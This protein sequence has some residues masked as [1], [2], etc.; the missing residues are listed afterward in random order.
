MMKYFYHEIGHAHL[1]GHTSWTGMMSSGNWY[2]FGL[3]EGEANHWYDIYSTPQGDC[4]SWNYD[5]GSSD[6]E[7]VCEPDDDEPD[8]S[9]PDDPGTSNN[10]EPATPADIEVVQSK[11]SRAR[12]PDSLKI[13]RENSPESLPNE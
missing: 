6:T 1:L 13:L 2:S 3:S 9:D 4:D 11:P 7:E 10:P 5:P 8:D 12:G